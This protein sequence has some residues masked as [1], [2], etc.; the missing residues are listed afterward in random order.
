MAKGVTLTPEETEELRKLFVKLVAR[1]KLNRI[2][3]PV[4]MEIYDKLTAAG[5][6][7]VPKLP[8]AAKPR[9]RA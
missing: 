6:E 4:L 9:R 8:R 3:T 7:E 1:W 5:I 2:E